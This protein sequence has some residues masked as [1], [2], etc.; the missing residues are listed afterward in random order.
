VQRRALRRIDAALRRR[1]VG[2][3]RFHARRLAG[4]APLSEEESR[5][6]HDRVV[7]YSRSQPSQLFQLLETFPSGLAVWLARKAGEAYEA[8]AFWEKGSDPT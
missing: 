1:G 2:H 3:R 7:D 6:I 4:L 5:E 8:G